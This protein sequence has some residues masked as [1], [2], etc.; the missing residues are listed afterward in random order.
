MS[1]SVNRTKGWGEES[2]INGPLILPG[3]PG[4]LRMERMTFSTDSAGIYPLAR[5]T[6]TKTWTLI[7]LCA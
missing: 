7:S 1:M 5:K 2:S 6:K 4:S 3:K